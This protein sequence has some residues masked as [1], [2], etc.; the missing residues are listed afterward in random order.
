MKLLKYLNLF[1]YFLIF[2]GTM[3]R[4]RYLRWR[5]KPHLELKSDP[6]TTLS[7]ISQYDFAKPSF[8][9]GTFTLNMILTGDPVLISAAP[10]FL[11][12][13]WTRRRIAAR[14]YRIALISRFEIA[15]RRMKGYHQSHLMDRVI[16]KLHDTEELSRADREFDGW[17]RLDDFN[18]DYKFYRE[19]Y[20]RISYLFQAVREGRVEDVMTIVSRELSVDVRES[21]LGT[22]LIAAVASKQP[23]VV[24]RLL[25]LGANPNLQT[26]IGLTALVWA[27]GHRDLN[28]TERLL[29]HGANPNLADYYYL[30]TPFHS[31]LNVIDPLIC[32]KFLEKGGDPRQEEILG[33]SCV[34]V[35]I[36][37]DRAD[38][39]RLFLDWGIGP[40][41]SDPLGAPLLCYAAM[42]GAEECVDV[43]I[44]HGAY[45]NLPG[46]KDATPLSL[47]AYSGSKEIAEKLVASGAE[48]DHLDYMDRTPLMLA[49]MGDHSGVAETLLE[50]GADPSRLDSEGKS[51][52][53]MAQSDEMKRVL[54]SNG[55]E[56]N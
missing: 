46:D 34:T 37:F 26:R 27:V 7:L 35:A 52:L 53:D 39:L 28:L 45:V 33:R 42:M 13:H 36:D 5:K 17:F 18:V 23:A 48:I 4:W 29:E 43:L 9:M 3:L 31:Y 30:R 19:N 49:A 44:G 11:K 1:G 51:V 15:R 6:D 25:E 20:S 21:N 54:E 40:N 14:V 47:A 50:L 38:H 8:Y 41:E 32:E 56:E 22:P 12:Y 16:R 55:K 24:E 10:D 2:W